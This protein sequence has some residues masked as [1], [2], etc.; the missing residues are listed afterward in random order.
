[1]KK[2]SVVPE[3]I[4]MTGCQELC[5]YFNV[6]EKDLI[7]TSR[8]IFNDY[9]KPFS[10]GAKTVF[11]E[12]FSNG[13]ATNKTVDAIAGY[14]KKINYNRVIVIGDGSVLD[15]GKLFCLET[16][17]PV[18][19]LF[20]GNIPAKR[21][22]ELIMV[23]TTCGTG[24]EVTSISTIEITELNT[25]KR[26]I[27]PELHVDYTV[28]I[29]TLLENLPFEM[30]TISSINAFMNCVES[31]LS[32]NA[33]PFSKIFSM[34][35][36]RTIIKGYIK[37]AQEG[38]TARF[39]ML[40]EFLDASAYSGIAFENA[41]CGAVSALSYPLESICRTPCQEAHYTIFLGVLEKYKQLKPSVG[42]LEVLECTW[43]KLLGCE[44]DHV[45]LELAKLFNYVV[46]KEPIREYCVIVN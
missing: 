44:K 5:S 45:Y 33:T 38:S 4:R 41:G 37:I 28:L 40:N 14:I 19:E 23:P 6:G 15:V 7:I 10:N 25:K 9:I 42:E 36:I 26:L 32:P 43:A 31:Y 29:P 2:N 22:K 34:K 16:V 3:I 17:A 27:L 18:Y 13:E 11:L 39:S 1:L 35:S 20:C 46:P 8:H 21:T 24:S 30:F 12:D